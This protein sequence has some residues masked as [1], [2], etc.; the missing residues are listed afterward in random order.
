MFLTTSFLGVVMIW[1]GFL[2]NMG[3]KKI[4]TDKEKEFIINYPYLTDRQRNIFSLYAIRGWNI[5]D[6]A[7]E[8]DIS[9]STVSNDLDKIKNILKENNY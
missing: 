5:E 2:Q 7:A 8:N 3:C 6:V 4:Y 9:R 1:G